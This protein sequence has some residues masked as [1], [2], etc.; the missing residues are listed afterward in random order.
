MSNKKT[1]VREA[2]LDILGETH[3]PSDLL[4]PDTGTTYGLDSFEDVEWGAGMLNSNVLEDDLLQDPGFPT[5]HLAAEDNMDLSVY[6]AEGLTDL[7]WLDP[8]QPQDPDRLPENPVDNMIPELVEAWGVNRRT[9]GVVPAR[10]LTAARY[11]ESLEEE[12]APVKRASAATIKKVLA[13]A[14]RR[15]ASGQDIQTI[16]VQTMESMGD[17]MGRIASAMKLIR[18]EHGLAGNVFIRASA[19]PGYSQGKWAKELRKLEARYVV[20]SEDE[21]RNA[22]WIK[23]GRCMFTGKIAVTEVPWKKALNFYAPRL[24]AVGR[25]VPSGDSREALRHAFLTVPEVKE[26]SK[27]HLPTHKAPSQLIS[28]SDAR[29][30]LAAHRPEQKVYSAKEASEEKLHKKVLARIKELANQGVLSA[31]DSK[32]LLRDTS[33]PLDLM[34][35]AALMVRSASAAKT[36]AYSGSSPRNAADTSYR[37]AEVKEHEPVVKKQVKAAVRWLRK[38]MSEGWAGKDLD[39]LISRRFARDLMADAGEALHEARQ[40][41]EG[42]SGFLY[43]DSEAYASQAGV[44]G[45]EEGALKHRANTIPTVASMDRCSSCA[46]ART[47]KDGNQKCAVYNKLLLSELSSPDLD[48][49]KK[50]N[51]KKANMN[52]SELTSSY[53]IAEHD[54]SFNLGNSNLDDV[55]PYPEGEEGLQDILFGGWDID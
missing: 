47:L 37:L 20:V 38:T 29:A 14:M 6:A 35:K 15:S 34:K 22:T 17:E 42:A 31:S 40:A 50:A 19:Y 36:G 44:R 4:T 30:A 49:V 54:D 33:H 39:D 46:H 23:N 25:E 9:N 41:H 2:D 55:A 1:R 43:V 52:D 7:S 3:I 53:F 8:T 32:A 12:S 26:G 48:R 10:D 16:T 45:C 13:H 28:K 24:E 51:I 5:V 18:E 11:E 27:D 21:L